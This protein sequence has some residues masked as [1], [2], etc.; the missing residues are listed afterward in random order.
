M[1]PPLDW[2]KAETRQDIESQRFFRASCLLPRFFQADKIRSLSSSPLVAAGNLATSCFNKVHKFLIG[3]M[4]GDCGAHNRRVTQ[5]WSSNHLLHLLLCFIQN[6]LPVA[7]RPRIFLSGRRPG[8]A[9]SIKCSFLLC[10][11]NLVVQSCLGDSEALTNVLCLDTLALE[12]Q[13]SNFHGVGSEKFFFNPISHR[14]GAFNTP[15]KKKLL[16]QPLNQMIL[17]WKNLTFPNSL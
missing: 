14:G 6:L 8:H 11:M 2:T 7:T 3:F 13:G 15:P 12:L 5:G 10:Q 9:W 17:T 4:S 16:L 1:G